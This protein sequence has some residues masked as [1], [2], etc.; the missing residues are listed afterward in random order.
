MQQIPIQQLPNQS[1]AIVLDSNEW[2]IAIKTTNGV[3]A[4]SLS[5]NNV[6]IVDNGIAAAGAFIIASI[7]EESGNFI[8]ITQNFQLPDYTLFGVTQYLI[9]VSASEL[10]A[11]RMQLPPPINAADFNPIAALP[12]RFQPVG[13]VEA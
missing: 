9:Y 3:T 12:L 13:Y 5:I 7:Y 2:T 10:I 8:F 4:V 1:L 11:Y 6:D